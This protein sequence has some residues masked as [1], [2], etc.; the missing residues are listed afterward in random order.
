MTIGQQVKARFQTIPALAE[1][2]HPN[3]DKIYPI[4]GGEI[5]Y[6]HPKGRFGTVRT[7]V[8]GGEVTETFRPCE[9]MA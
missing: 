4:R 1:E 2:S 8:A 9:V 6:I 7:S 5:V 3:K